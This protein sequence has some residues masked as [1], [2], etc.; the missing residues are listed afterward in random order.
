MFKQMLY[1]LLIV[2]GVSLAGCGSD[3]SGSLTLGSLTNSGR[4]VTASATYKPASG[5]A[6]PNQ[7]ITFYW[8]TVSASGVTLDYPPSDSFTDSNGIALSVLTLPG[9]EA[10]RVSVKAG[11]GDLITGSQSVEVAQSTF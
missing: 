1:V 11:T 8:R 2:A 4:E 10:F 3:N 6:L 9:T 5:S 7:K